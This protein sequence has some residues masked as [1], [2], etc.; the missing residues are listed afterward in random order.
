M[1]DHSFGVL[2]ALRIL[3]FGVVNQILVMKKIYKVN[4][5]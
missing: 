5:F 1:G 2:G 4:S 3:D